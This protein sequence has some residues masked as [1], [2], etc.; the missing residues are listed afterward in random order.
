MPRCDAYYRLE[1]RRC[2]HE[3]E[4]LSLASDHELY[5]V[6]SDHA[7]SAWTTRVAHWNGETDLRR[8]SPV[9]LN[10]AAAPVREVAFA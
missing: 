3:G 6:C 4:H 7:G 10:S 2:S 8:T 1:N 9:E 5:T